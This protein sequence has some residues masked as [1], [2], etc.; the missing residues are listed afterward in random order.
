MQA[1]MAAL[2]VGDWGRA[3]AA[4]ERAL[5]AREPPPEAHLYLGVA[6]WRAG[7][8]ED[9]ARTLETATGLLPR[10]AEA[11][12]FLGLVRFELRRLPAAREALRR[13]ASRDPTS[14]SARLGLARVHLNLAQ[15]ERGIGEVEVAARLEPDNAAIHTTRAL[16]AFRGGDLETAR[17]AVTRA[18]ELDPDDAET[19]AL[20]V[21][22]ALQEDDFA[23]ARPLATELVEERPTDPRYRYL[24]AS[25]LSGLGD[26]DEAAE[27]FRSYRALR[28]VTEDPTAGGMATAAGAAGPTATAGPAAA[29]RPVGAAGAT[30]RSRRRAI[31]ASLV[32]R[33][34]QARRDG[35]GE[36]AELLARLAE[37]IDASLRPAALRILGLVHYERNEFEAAARRMQE[38][39]DQGHRSASLAHDLVLSLI[40]S[41]QPG[42]AATLLGPLLDDPAWEG[43]GDAVLHYLRAT[44]LLEAGRPEEAVQSASRAVE[45]DPELPSPHLVLSRAYE[46]L[47]RPEEAER[48]MELYRRLLGR[49]RFGAPRRAQ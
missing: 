32:Q 21:E 4:F 27:E 43:A 38:L 30:D 35:D 7:R 17:S 24:L 33:A 23:A 20:R 11:H 13:A 34:E 25:V 42:R 36:M 1:G 37:D 29:A 9:A 2:N 12:L 14:A 31:A 44:A 28:S 3:V 49:R 39:W 8:L 40:Q 48:E 26:D 41:G 45:L 16:L 46:R 6:L 19:R 15:L 10:S 22:I 47:G 18:L 5:E